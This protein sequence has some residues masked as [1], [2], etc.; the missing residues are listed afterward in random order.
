MSSLVPLCFLSSVISSGLGRCRVL[1]VPSTRTETEKL[2]YFACFY[3][4][5]ERCKPSWSKQAWM[6][7]S[8]ANR[9]AQTC[10]ACCRQIKALI[11]Q[12][13]P[14]LRKVPQLLKVGFRAQRSL[15]AHWDSIQ[16]QFLR[17]LGS[18]CPP[19][20]HTH[21]VSSKCTKWPGR[22]TLSK[23]FFFFSFFPRSAGDSFQVNGQIT[24]FLK[25]N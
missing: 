6:H 19:P 12:C 14:T 23:A 21:T 3:S 24:I 1:S 20:P 18:I 22:E 9:A 11:E 15:R 13:Q 16:Q 2:N 4:L 7:S 10:Q 25:A 17:M 5:P 8:A